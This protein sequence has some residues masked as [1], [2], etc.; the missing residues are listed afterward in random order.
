M[1]SLSPSPAPLFDTNILA[2]TAARDAH[3]LRQPYEGGSF[4][5]D[6]KFAYFFLMAGCDPKQKERY[7]GYVLNILVS[8]HILQQSGSNADVVVL[9][10]MSSET[11]AESIEEQ[12]MLE[13][14]G[15]IVRYLPKVH[16]DN[17]F[18]AMLDKFQILKYY[19]EYDRII[20]LDSDIT[21]FCNLDYMFHNS[22]GPDAT[23]APNVILSYKHEPAQ[24]GFFMVHPEE[25]DYEKIQEIIDSRVRSSYNFSEKYG[26]GHKI[27]YPDYWGKFVSNFFFHPSSTPTSLCI[28]WF[29]R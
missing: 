2:S 25:G 10:R 26:W 7:I 13:R 22:M 28:S 27:L 12:E 18:S 11:T 5:G 6:G 21:P 8:K 17:F 24:G 23:L 1:V 3:S 4:K 14:G 29:D 19:A 16:L 15:V 9:T 20:F